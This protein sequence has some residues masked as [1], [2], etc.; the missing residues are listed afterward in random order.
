ME[1]EI[2]IAPE[3]AKK[4]YPRQYRVLQRAYEKRH[5]PTDSK[6]YN[7]VVIVEHKRHVGF[8]SAELSIGYYPY[9]WRKPIK[10]MPIELKV[11]NLDH[12]WVGEKKVRKDAGKTEAVEAK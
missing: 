4:R 10:G 8:A 2:T 12:R 3:E 5:G 1:M 11:L 7:W 6:Y 9:R